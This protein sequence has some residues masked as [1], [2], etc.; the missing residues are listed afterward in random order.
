MSLSF[1][2]SER[3]LDVLTSSIVSQKVCLR[4]VRGALF[5]V[6]RSPFT[7]KFPTQTFLK[8]EKKRNIFGEKNKEMNLNI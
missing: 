1:C 2:P 8:K 4:V 5:R 7:Q 3:R 6:G